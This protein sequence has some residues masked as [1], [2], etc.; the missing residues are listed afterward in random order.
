M[1][2]A[3]RRGPAG[4]PAGA[5]RADGPERR[6]VHARIRPRRLRGGHRPVAAAP[7][8]P[9]RRHRR[10]DRAGARGGRARPVRSRLRGIPEGAGPR[11]AQR[12]RALLPDDP[13]GV[14]AQVEYERLLAMAPDSPRA[15]QLLGDLYQAQERPQ[16]A[17]TEYKAGLRADPASVDLLVSLGDLARHAGAVRGSGDV[18][19]ARR[20]DRASPLRRP[21]R[22]RRLPLLSAGVRPGH[23]V[24]PRRAR[25]RPVVGGRA[26]RPR[27]RAPP[28]GPGGGGRARAREGG[29]ARAADDAGTLPPGPRLPALGRAEEAAAVFEKVKALSQGQTLE[30]QAARQAA[31]PPRPGQSAGAAALARGTLAAMTA[32]WALLLGA[33]LLAPRAAPPTVIAPPSA[34]AAHGVAYVDATASSGPRPFPS[35]V[36]RCGQGL[37]P[38]SHGVRRR[39]RRLRRRRMAR[40]VPR[41]RL[42]VRR[43]ARRGGGARGRALPQQP[44]RHV[45]GRDGRRRRRERALGPGRLRRRLRQ[46]RPGGLFVT[47]FGRNRLY[48]NRGDGTFADVAEVAGRGR[49]RLVHG[50]RLRRLRRR[51]QARPVRGRLRRARSRAAAAAP[52]RTGTRRRETRPPPRRRRRRSAAWARPTPRARAYCEYR[53]QP[54]MC[55]PRGLKGA[56]D[57]LFRND[58]DGTLHRRERAR[59]GGGRRRP[60]RLRRRV[61]RL[62]R[63]RQAR[64][65]RRQR[66]HAQLPLPQPRR[67]H[68]PGRQLRLGRRPRRGGPRAGAHGRG[69]G[70][71]RQR[72]ARRP[73]HHELR[74][75]LQRA[76]PQRRQGTLLGRELSGGRRP[77]EHPVPGLGR[78]TSSTTTTTAGSTSS[79][80]TATSTRSW[81]S[82]D[83]NTS[84]RQRA[85]LFR[86]LRGKFVEVAGSAGA[87]LAVPRASRGSG[88][89]RPRQRRRRRRRRSTTSTRL[90]PSCATTA[91]AGPDT[92]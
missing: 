5:A 54:V 66:L 77:S 55:G 19:R 62:R 15:H 63:R 44:R 84:Y 59:G 60:L 35:R 51:R 12:R 73:A 48:R 74:R 6:R 40:R 86:N 87:G 2:W 43:P 25:G 34:S 8:R 37:H 31:D 50:M 7:G 56:P 27:P 67:R 76:L 71:L 14:L 49:G 3:L 33:V 79:S 32:R 1:L 52:L 80:P 70:R 45:H 82:F 47:N 21:L 89:G 24:F 72:R 88:R 18:L 46:R 17:E 91:G 68:L 20:E 57:R 53:G 85:L 69:R 10:P 64:P 75:R 38:R 83:W 9:A 65:L 26:P 90:P 29:R 58:G 61:L 41:Q 39:P 36:G 22:A 23:R 28:V 92:G 78:R 13:G 42:H 16:D 4:R 30:E 11:T 81:T